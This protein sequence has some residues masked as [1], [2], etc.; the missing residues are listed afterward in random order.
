MIKT[1]SENKNN[2]WLKL[3]HHVVTKTGYLPP[4][5]GS[6]PKKN[7]DTYFAY[8]LDSLGVFGVCDGHGPLGHLVS[9]FIQYELPH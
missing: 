4:R 3:H 7:Q 6:M 2:R 8:N 5:I 1:P 9:S